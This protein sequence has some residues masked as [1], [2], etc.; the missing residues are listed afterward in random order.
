MA[1]AMPEH[2]IRLRKAWGLDLP[3]GHDAGRLDLPVESLA[4]EAPFHLSRC[5]T[6]PPALSPDAIVELRIERIPGLVAARLDGAGIPGNG[7]RIDAI[8]G[9]RYVLVLEIDPDGLS[10]ADR[11]DW[12]HVALAIRE[13]GPT[14]L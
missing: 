11:R 8:P 10:E 2:I 4:F 12:G 7:S 14:P 3:P 5:W 9:R 1:S 13:P 6:A